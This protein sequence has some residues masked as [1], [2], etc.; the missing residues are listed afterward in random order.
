MAKQVLIVLAALETCLFGAC[1]FAGMQIQSVQ[2]SLDSSAAVS[3]GGDKLLKSVLNTTMVG[4]VG[5]AGGKLGGGEEG[6]GETDSKSGA[7]AK[8][9]DQAIQNVKTELSNLETITAQ[10]PQ[11]KARVE[12][13]KELTGKIEKVGKLL[14]KTMGDGSGGM[15]MYL[16]LLKGAKVLGKLVD[17]V[18]TEVDE[19]Q[20]YEKTRT[21]ALAGPKT[22]Y[23]L[24]LKIC[25]GVGILV[26]LASL[27]A[28]AKSD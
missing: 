11:Q 4:S 12:T 5:M 17:K 14:Q 24:V 26:G 25:A 8:G 27:A 20:S 13:L 3:H 2:S 16:S 9:F 19:L 23:D 18:A 22:T 1:G 6:E 21:D 10:D 7:M 28:A 15:G